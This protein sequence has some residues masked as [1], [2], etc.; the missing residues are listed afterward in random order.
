[1]LLYL[2]LPIALLVLSAL[3]WWISKAPERG[4]YIAF[5]SSGILNTV[6]L[7]PLRDKV[8]LT[9][10]VVLLTWFAM[11]VNHSWRSQRI[12]LTGLQ[13]LALL[14]LAVFVLTE[15]VS[16]LVN[17]ADFYGALTG[18]LVET[19]NI[20]YGSLMVVTVIMLIKTPHQWKS[21]LVGW[22]AGS[23]LVSSVG[24]WA[25]SG[26]APSW[27]LDEYTGRI[28]STLKFENQ[29]PS[30]IIPI[31]MVSLIWRVS[32][33]LRKEQRLLISTLILGMVVILIGTGS[34]TALL[35]LIIVAM[36]LPIVL[37]WQINNRFLLKGSLGLNIIMGIFA[38]F[39]YISAA[40]TFYDGD[41]L[42]GKTP[43]WQ[44]PVVMMYENFTEGSGVD[45]TR[46]EQASLVIEKADVAMFIGNGPKLYGNKFQVE[47][48][49]NTYAGVYIETG[50]MGLITLL[51]FLMLT[52]TTIFRA[53]P[54][55]ELRLL[56]IAAGLGFILLIIYNLT[57]Y[58]LRQRTLWLMA[59]LLLSSATLSKNRIE[60][61]T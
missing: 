51:I 44:R 59:G 2:I 26:S 16:F 38:L 1:M 36:F 53:R 25:M 15:W 58:G 48:I 37:A 7:G 57:M 42:L 11:L 56:F 24:L 60:H 47:E 29:I 45:T 12:F 17:N 43:A 22:L 8:G 40:M 4:I 41:Y 31:L 50:L 23:L 54:G 32:S 14:F 46:L 28:S 55:S 21:C 6:S 49:H 18:S 13:R 27:T 61:H 10:I 35:L 9:E 33:S 5:F 52:I 20:T 30:Y 34:R 19:L 3:F 39:T